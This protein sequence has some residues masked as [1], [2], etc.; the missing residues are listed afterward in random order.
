MPSA[1]SLSPTSRSKEPDPDPLGWREEGKDLCRAVAAGSIVGMPLLYTMEMWW[2]GMT[3]SSAHLLLLL[4]VTL[5]TNFAFSLFS[6]FR[7]QYSVGE[8]AGEAVS[9]VALGLLYSIAV[10]WLIGEITFTGAATSDVLGRVLVQTAPVS[11]G[12][13]FANIQVRDKA[14]QNERDDDDQERG[15][16]PN[17]SSGD[18]D[19]NGD[20]QN[21]EDNDP[22]RLQLK[23][24]LRDFAAAVGGAAVFTFSLAPTEEILLIAA[25]IPAWQHLILMAASLLLC[26]LILFAAGFQQRPVHVPSPFQSP[27]AETA[28]AYAVSLLT[29]FILLYLIGTREATSSLAATLATTV[30]LGLPA[31]V[32]A[33]AGRLIL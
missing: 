8:A 7:P 3:L 19:N 29:A 12:I 23:Q 26:Y 31:V 25:R 2:H 28:M 5:V 9:A 24:D 11:L 16:A 27:L 13:A 22:E 32:G 21:N 18:K 15:Q 14:Q 1:A 10:L 4:A 33:S 30:T 6:G 17:D 20:K